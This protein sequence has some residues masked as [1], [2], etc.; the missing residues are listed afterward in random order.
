MGSNLNGVPNAREPISPQPHK[1]NPI[2]G[3]K[4]SI[5]V[6]RCP[7]PLQA[8]HVTAAALASDI[9]DTSFEGR[10]KLVALLERALRAERRRGLAGHWTYDLARHLQ[11]LDACRAEKRALHALASS[12]KKRPRNQSFGAA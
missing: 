4:P 5:A 12:N 1:Q 8:S 6:C 3:A 11:L 9:Q 10:S 7:G 2:P